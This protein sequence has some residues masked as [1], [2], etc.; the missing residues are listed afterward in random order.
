MTPNWAIGNRA[1]DAMYKPLQLQVAAECGLRTPR[2]VVTND[3]EV[4]TTFAAELDHGVVIKTLGANTITEGGKLKVVFTHRLSTSD[5]ADL[6]GIDLTAHQL[7]E[8][9]PKARE[10]RVVTVGDQLF[11][12]MIDAGTAAAQVDWRIDYDSLSYEL[13]TLPVEVAAGIRAY[14]ARFSLTYAAFDFAIDSQ[15]RYWFFEANT[16]GQFGWLEAH[17]GAPIIDT[18]ASTLAEGART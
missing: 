11:P 16:S 2:T 15:G 14:L 10:M 3:P 8:W 13:T 4:V 6:R 7:Q 1:A 12:I 18:I 17:T 9:I 5:L